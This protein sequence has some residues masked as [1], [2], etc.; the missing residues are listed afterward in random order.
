VGNGRPN[1]NFGAI[2]EDG[3]GVTS[4][5]NGLA[6]Q[7]HKQFSHGLMGDLSYTWSHEIDDGQGYGQDSYTFYG[8]SLNQYTYNGNFQFERGNGLL[9]LRHRL[10]LSFVWQPTITHRSGAFYTYVVNNWQLSSILTAD[11]SRPTQFN[12]PKVFTNDSFGF[13]S[14]VVFND[15]SLNGQGLNE[16]VPFWPV[17]TVLAPPLIRDDIRISKIIPINE[18]FKA[19]INLEIFNIANNWS[20]TVVAVGNAYQEHNSVLTPAATPVDGEFPGC[21]CSDGYPIDGTEAR[22]LQISG[23]L[24]F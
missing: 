14:G 6:V 7:L 1:P 4:F 20:P 12:S 18:R 9:D 3:N 13:P 21:A 10:S 2:Y 8:S 23:R 24:T 5:Y 22:R 16:R 11:S 15:F 17:N 19:T